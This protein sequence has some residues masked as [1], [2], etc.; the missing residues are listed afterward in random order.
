MGSCC[1]SSVKEDYGFIYL[2]LDKINLLPGEKIDGLILLS[3]SKDFPG[4]NISLN[5]EGEE[6]CQWPQ[7]TFTAS[8][9][10]KKK[11]LSKNVEIYRFEEGIAKAG[12]YNFPISFT[13]DSD[14][15]ATYTFANSKIKASVSYKMTG[16]LFF[17]LYLS[18]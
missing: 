17:Y 6:F 10:L 18:F 3:L 14:L 15:P 1:S 2:E 7:S 9:P 13:L 12:D 4:S 8:T 16:I 11:I 5:F